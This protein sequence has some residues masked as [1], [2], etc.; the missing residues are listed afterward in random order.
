M[1]VVGW[2]EGHLPHEKHIPLI[3]EMLFQNEW[4]RRTWGNRLT[5]IHLEKRQLG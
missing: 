4:R 3:P 1:L 2:Q 5:Q